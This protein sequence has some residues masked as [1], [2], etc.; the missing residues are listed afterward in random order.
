[1]PHNWATG[2]KQPLFLK[3]VRRKPKKIENTERYI[4]LYADAG[5]AHFKGG[6]MLDSIEL[7][8]LA[9][10]KFET[11]P[12]DNTDVEY[13]TLKQRLVYTMRGVAVPNR[14]DHSSELEA[15]PAGFCSNPDTDEKVLDLPRFSNWR[16]L[17]PFSA[18]R[19]QVWA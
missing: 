5:F 15:L 16:G 18:N 12:Q 17:D 4:G 14:Q 2:R 9:L 19:V 7:L 1:M 6:N 13:F 8:S 10:Q 11:I 3:A